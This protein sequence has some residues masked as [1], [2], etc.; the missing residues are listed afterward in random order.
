MKQRVIYMFMPLF[1]LFVEVVGTAFGCW[2]WSSKPFG[3]L[4]TTNPPMGSVMFYVY[5]DIIVMFLGSMWATTWAT[6]ETAA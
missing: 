5:L 3:I 4:S 2:S 6:E 1:V